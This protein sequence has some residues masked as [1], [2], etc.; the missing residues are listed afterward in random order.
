MARGVKGRFQRYTIH[1]AILLTEN[2]LSLGKS[3]SVATAIAALTTKGAHAFA[4]T[5]GR[6]LLGTNFEAKCTLDLP[7][8]LNCGA[9]RVSEDQHF[10]MKCGAKLTT[11]SLYDELLRTSFDR[12]PL[13]AKKIK[14][15]R[16]HTQIKTIQDILLD[17]ELQ[18]LRRV[19][20]IGPVWSARIRGYAE[21]FVSV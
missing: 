21:E 2:A 11:A 8:C 14:G 6:A 5:K 13:S 9:P 7:K 3:Y 15:I 17:D 4:R 10:C 19:P 20:Y 18:T 16:E 1:N 12:L